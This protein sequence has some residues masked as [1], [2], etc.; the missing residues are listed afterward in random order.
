KPTFQPT[1]LNL[2][3][4]SGIGSFDIPTTETGSNQF[5]ADGDGLYDLHF[6]FASGGDLTNWFSGGD[7]AVYLITGISGLTAADFQYQSAPS[8]GIGPFYAAAHV[9]RL[10]VNANKSSWFEP[11]G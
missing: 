8:G 5:K 7:S 11:T 1:S 3:Y 6:I 2:A 4:Q 9:Q 10:G